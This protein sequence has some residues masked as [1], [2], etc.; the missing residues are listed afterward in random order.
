MAKQTLN[1][2]E[3]GLS[4]RTKINSMF[5]DLYGLTFIQDTPSTTWTVPHNL[6]YT[7][8]VSAFTTG[9]VEFMVDIEH[10]SPDVSILRLSAPMSGFARFS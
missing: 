1:N 6:G 3:T 7:P 4:F 2:R 8:H 5:S 9:G 10:Q